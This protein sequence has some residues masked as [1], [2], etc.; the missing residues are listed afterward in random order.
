M[1]HQLAGVVHLRRPH[2]HSR[3]TATFDRIACDLRIGTAGLEV[4]DFVPL[5]TCERC[6][7]V[8]ARRDLAFDDP[9]MD[10]T[11]GA[12]PAW[13]RGHDHTAAKWLQVGVAQTEHLP[14]TSRNSVDK[15]CREYMQVE[16]EFCDACGARAA[17]EELKRRIERL[18]GTDTAREGPGESLAPSSSAN[19]G[20]S[21]G[22]KGLD[23]NL[24][25]R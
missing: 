15:T 3:S 25:E 4:T 7:A 19:Q 14:C 11:D 21:G 5:V 13:W 6:I 22:V 20:A 17:L 18:G 8:S 2:K 10:A 12:H 24:G 23:E 16:R 1:T 9:G